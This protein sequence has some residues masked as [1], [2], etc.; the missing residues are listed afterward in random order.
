MANIIDGVTKWVV[1]RRAYARQYS[2]R[3]LKADR[4]PPPRLA[5]TFLE[6][7]AQSNYSLF[8]TVDDE[9][10][11]EL[12]ATCSWVY[13]D[14][15]LIANRISGEAARPVAAYWEDGDWQE[16]WEHPVNKLIARPN[17]LISGSFMFRYLAWWYLL[18]GNAYVFVSTPQYGRGEPQELWPLVANQVEPLPDTLRETPRGLVVDYAYSIR[19]QVATLP[20]EH[21]IHFR[22]PNPWDYWRGL[23]PLTASLIAIQADTNRAKWDRDFFGVDNAIPTAVISLPAEITDSD[24]D[25]AQEEIRAEFGGRRRTAITRAGDLSIETI[26]QTLADMQMSEMRLLSRDEI[27]RVYGVPEGIFSSASGESR[28]AV[29]SLFATNT[30]QPMVDYFA[31][32]WTNGLAWFYGDPDLTIYARPLVPRDKALA[33]Q[34]YTIYSHDRTI[35]ENRSELGLKPIKNPLA[36]EVP[37]RLLQWVAPTYPTIDGEEPEKEPVPPQLLAF[38]GQQAPAPAP[39]E[40]VQETAQV[41]AMVDAQAPETVVAEEASKAAMEGIRTEL[42]RWQKVALGEVRA[43]RLAGAREFVSDVLPEGVAAEV[44]EGL[45]DAA[46]E[47]AVR[48]VFWQATKVDPTE[49]IRRA[50]ERDIERAFIQGHTDGGTVGQIANGVVGPD[51]AFDAAW[52][53]RFQERLTARVVPALRAAATTLATSAAGTIGIEWQLVNQQVLAWAQQYGYGLI[54]DLTATTQAQLQGTISSWI[55]SGAPMPD[56]ISQLTPIFNNPVRAEAIGVT[57]VTRLYQMAN[58]MAWRQANIDIDAGIVGGEWRTARDEKTCPTCRPL[59]GQQRSL[60]SPGYMHPETGEMLL[61]PA[62]VRCRCSEVPVLSKPG[63]RQR[64]PGPMRGGG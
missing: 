18:S 30:I 31:E 11:Q 35:N 38:Q 57:E 13:S 53:T 51:E 19:G 61:M 16:D 54:S 10:A 63:S 52:R 12:A 46:D 29:E 21:I 6:R 44:R 39:V 59:H 17:A 20:G 41:G 5:A 22:T 48:A 45:A 37:V 55:A 40:E 24:F 42:K 60:Q 58:E 47:P 43:G 26:Q 32:E 62:H 4:I 36:E 27:D 15:Q 9:Q 34:E 3:A 1:D 50:V 33:I 7:L 14:I 25:R 56:L 8:R 23:S 2:A 49:A 28:M 64:G